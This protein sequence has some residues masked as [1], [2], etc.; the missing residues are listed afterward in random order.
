MRRLS[1][2]V[3]TGGALLMAAPALAQYAEFDG[4]GPTT[5]AGPDGVTVTPGYFRRRGWRRDDDDWG[6]RR[7]YR[8]WNRNWDD[9]GKVVSRDDGGKVVSRV[10]RAP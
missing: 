8:R 5:Y 2:A 6:Y 7:H 1:F 3:I 4:A 9:G 10:A